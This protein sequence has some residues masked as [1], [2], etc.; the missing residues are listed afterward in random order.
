MIVVLGA[1]II[2]LFC[3]LN[4][5]KHGKEVK[6]IDVENAKGTASNAAVGM[7][8]PL[9]EARPS[10]NQ[11]F[12]LMLESKEIW[13]LSL[14]D[15]IFSKNTGLKHNSS[16]LVAQNADDEE[17]IKFK[18][19]FFKKL[20]FETQILNP[21]ETMEIEPNLN[22]NV[23]CSLL[24]KNHNQIEPILLKKLLIEKVI[25]MGGDIRNV[26]NLDSF[27]FNDK[28]LNT[29]DK[30]FD[31]EKIIIAC[32]AWSNIIIEKSLAISFPTRPVKG[33]SMLFSTDTQLFSNNIW[34]R[35]VYLAPRKNN[36]LAVG[37]T[38]DDKGFDKSISLDEIHFIS[39]S[40]WEYLPEIEKLRF[41]NAFS[42]LRSGVIDGNPIIGELKVNNNIIC[43]FGHFRH[44]I[45][46]APVTAKIVCDYVFGKKIEERYNFFSP[47]RFNL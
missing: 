18:K 30:N 19:K 29:Y 14:K 10:E 9:I 31:A 46:L 17:R 3:A 20:G 32:G 8:A 47:K 15:L 7:L 28:K 35:N 42:G 27:E 11:L 6:I 34:F 43:A 41:E 45:L 36:L 25:N 12:K 4:L 33:V 40:L 38:E 24:C 13:D 1:G 2:G 23:K 16:I 22:S 37:A 44:G 5:L 21:S 26:K 39:K